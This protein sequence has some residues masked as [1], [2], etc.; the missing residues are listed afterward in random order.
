MNRYRLNECMIFSKKILIVI[1]LL[2]QVE[3]MNHNIDVML[4]LYERLN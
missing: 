2:T 3:Y 1:P 4:L